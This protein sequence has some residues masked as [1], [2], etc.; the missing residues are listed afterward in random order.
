MINAVLV[1]NYLITRGYAVLVL[2]YLIT[3]GYY[4]I[5][6][7]LFFFYYYPYSLL[8]LHLGQSPSFLTFHSSFLIW[9]LLRPI[10]LLLLFITHFTFRAKPV[11]SHFSFLISHLEFASAEANSMRYALMKS[12]IFPSMTPSTSEV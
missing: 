10:L 11:I 5:D 8:I 12:S 7:I 4:Y 6:I 3:R 9:N 1:L 2:N